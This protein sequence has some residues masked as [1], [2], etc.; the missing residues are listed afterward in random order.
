MAPIFIILECIAN[1]V[2]L[3]LLY[4]LD[5]KIDPGYLSFCRHLVGSVDTI[6][7]DAETA[8]SSSVALTSLVFLSSSAFK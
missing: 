1:I 7:F 8:K 4:I 5:R 2:E 3:S 6:L